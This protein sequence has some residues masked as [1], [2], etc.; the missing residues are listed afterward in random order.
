MSARHL[1]FAAFL[2]L[3]PAAYGVPRIH[4]W[5]LAN[6]A[7]IYFVQAPS[8]PMI[9]VNVAFDAGSARDPAGLNG[10]AMITNSM[11]GEGAGKL[12]TGQIDRR[13][14]DVGA[15]LGSS[16]GRD[17]ASVSL[18][19]LAQR[20][21]QAPAVRLFA[22]ALA[23][24]SF[25]AKD[26]ARK[27]RE[28]LISLKLSRQ[29]LSSVASRK[30]MK[31]VYPTHPYGDYPGGST[32]GL[33][34]IT[35]PAVVAFYRRYYV[36]R[37]ATVAIV[38][39]ISLATA[40][41][42][43]KTIAGGL[44]PGTRPPPLPRVPPLRRA[45]FV[46]ILYPSVQT[47]IMIGQPGVARGDPDYFP[48]LVGNYILGG[49]PLESRL[50]IELRQKHALSYTT[51][52]Y[53]YPMRRPGPFVISVL[54]RNADRVIALRLARNTLAQFLAHG[55][56]RREVMMAKR[57]L[58]GSF[59]LHIDSDGKLVQ[60]LTAIGFYG[61]P[62]DYLNRFIPNVRAVTRSEIIK[63]FRNHVHPKRMVTLV[64]GGRKE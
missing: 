28:G 21:M 6:G 56:T 52:S 46:R 33:A 12:T 25:P 14:D 15:S 44:P 17:M 29:S 32:E 16:S 34:R 37:N 43:A 62:L 23:H 2:L 7:R 54:T 30:F 11:V 58:T 51:Y 64:V 60:V 48:L 61:L 47:Q 20:R 39:D 4:H 42:I 31:L 45:R 40:H 27:V 5:T 50:A 53:F 41:H 24:P 36:G 8:V 13:L 63:D 38:G 10:L 3:P 22:L 19:S 59:P 9:D 57:Y 26:L 49:D 1:L 35:R 55:P 18:Q